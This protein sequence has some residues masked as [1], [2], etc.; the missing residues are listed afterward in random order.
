MGARA[1]KKQRWFRGCC[2]I[3]SESFQPFLR[4]AAIDRRGNVG[5]EYHFLYDCARVIPQ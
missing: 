4:A 5:F 3:R 2:R 1:I